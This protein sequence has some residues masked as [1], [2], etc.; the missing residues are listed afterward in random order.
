MV[1]T[2]KKPVKKVASSKKRTKKMPKKPTNSPLL[3]APKLTKKYMLIF[4]VMFAIAG[5]YFLYQTYAAQR[6]VNYYGVLSSSNPKAEYKLTTGFGVMDVSFSNNT[7]DLNL[8][9][10]DSD[11]KVVGNLDSR[12]KKDV[13][14]STMV[15][16][17]V[18]TFTL[19][20][21][22][23]FNKKKGYSVKIDYPEVDS[24]SPTV[25][26]TEPLNKESVKK[27]S[28]ISVDANDDVKVVKV[29]MFVDGKIVKK[30]TEE[31]WWTRWDT[32]KFDDGPATISVKA[33]D[34]AGN[35]GEASGTV[36]IDNVEDAA[37]KAESRFPGDP[38]PKV[39]NK[40]Y[41]G[42]SIGGNGDPDRHEGPTGSSLAIRRTFWQW[43]AATNNSSSMYKTIEDDLE[44]NRLPFIST[45]TPSWAE[46]GSGK[47]DA[48][49]DKI[50]KKLDSYGK[51][52]WFVAHHE[53]EGG[54]TFGNTPDDPGGP[55]AWRE[56]QK[57]FRE[58]INAV[59]TKN[60]AF[61]PVV[62]TYTWNNASKR[63]PNDWWVDGIWDAY[64][65]DH[66]RHKVEGTPLD[67]TWFKFVDWIEDR[68]LPFCVGE[69]G[70]RGTDAEAGRE[71]RDFWEWSFNNDKD[72]IGYSYFDSGLNSPGGSWELKGE[73]LKVFQDILKNDNK[74]QRINDLE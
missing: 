58:R 56:M 12:G 74:V 22:T 53:P 64:C 39:N 65:V 23:A 19:T 70:T 40:T 48:A 30:D 32:R 43:S 52:I 41:W 35:V 17:D 44:N 54:G 68:G 10:V 24:T 71:V 45:K 60:I 63:T 47:H 46:V 66:Y 38:N 6:F 42:S 34:E 31:P 49:I 51:P 62:M 27:T 55:A 61:M 5:S 13:K 14:L 8:K 15:E 28:T 2:K 36:F 69:W 20:S 29:E 57:K 26:I 21:K 18:Y 11:N 25:I 4:G 59:G 67:D 3:S 16:P 72:F 7:A 33:Y 37:E 50:L 9:I 1:Q 73:Q